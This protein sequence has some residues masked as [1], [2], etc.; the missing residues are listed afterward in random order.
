MTV[1]PQI[2]FPEPTVPRTGPMGGTE[3]RVNFYLQSTRPEAVSGRSVVNEW[4]A[5]FP[6]P[7]GHFQRRLRSTED[8]DHEGPLD[9]LFIYQRLIRN[10]RVSYE[11]GGRGPD[12]RL[13]RD[14]VHIAS[15]E[16]ISL[17][18]RHDWEARQARHDRIAD[19]LNRR[20]Q[21]ADGACILRLSAWID[22]HQ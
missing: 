13:Y 2:P 17:F 10:A 22:H 18:M 3:P 7:N 6:D 5:R 1:L 9:E 14:S 8:A 4:Y 19:E 16:M 21:V 12:F 15:V 20:L 11:E